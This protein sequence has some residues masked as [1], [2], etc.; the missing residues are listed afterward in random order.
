MIRHGRLGPASPVLLLPLT[1]I[2]SCFR[3]VPVPAVGIP[4][5]LEA[6]SFAAGEAAIALPAVTMGTK[7]EHRVAFSAQANP[8]PENHFAM[9][10]HASSQAGLDNGNGFVAL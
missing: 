8:L 6:G 9:L 10:R 7:I 4:V 3:T 5:L 1:M 2:F